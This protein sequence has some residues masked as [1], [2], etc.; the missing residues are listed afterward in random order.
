LEHVQGN[1]SVKVHLQRAADRSRIWPTL[2]GGCH[3]SRDTVASI[4][5]AGFEIERVESMSLGPSFLITNPHVV[6]VARR[7]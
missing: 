7:P 1:K 3:C 2:V 4:R 6:G 5:G